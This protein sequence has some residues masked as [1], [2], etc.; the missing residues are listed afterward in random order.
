MIWAVFRVMFLSMIRD[1]GAFAMAFVLPPLIYVIFAAIF[2]VTAGGDLRIK[3]AISD[4]VRSEASL[5]LTAALQKSDD[6]QVETVAVANELE[7]ENL[8]R[9]AVVDAGILIKADPASLDRKQTPIKILGDAGR[10]IAIPIVTGHILRTFGASLPDVVFQQSAA[11]LESQVGEFSKEQRSR[12]DEVA[13]DLKK[14]GQGDGP[15]GDSLRDLLIESQTIKQRNAASPAVV[16]YAGAVAFMFLMFAAAQSAMSLIDERD[17]G[18]VDRIVAGT[19]GVNVIVAGKFAFL[20]LQGI[21]Q[22]ALIFGIASA[23]YKVELAPHFGAWLVITAAAAACAA[24]FG[25][26]VAC[27]C[28]TRQQAATL[29]NF[30]VLVLSAI[31][32]SMVPRFLMPPWL[33]DLSWI[34]PN[35]WAIEAYHR[36]LWQGASFNEV[37]Q[38]ALALLGAAVV[39]LA[40]STLVL[41]SSGQT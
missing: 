13:A 23:L 6:V 27:L 24:S 22:C 8:V 17:S 16:Y 31:G 4:Q 29:S 18:I 40:I 28:K 32:G 33:Q 1:R 11:D 39:G 36:L 7:L 14:E 38:P 35:A 25:L 41:R 9:R 12:R 34:T 37:F 19:G 10:A 3:V 26:L 5:R 21:V 15:K 20:F 2:S 30:M